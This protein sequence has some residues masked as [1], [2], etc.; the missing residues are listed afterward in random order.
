MRRAEAVLDGLVM[1]GINRKRLS[2]VGK[3]ATEKIAKEVTEDDK[4]LNR[5]VVIALTRSD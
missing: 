2:A 5:R 3:G 4:A 1:A